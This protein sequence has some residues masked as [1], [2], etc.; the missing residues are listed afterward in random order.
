MNKKLQFNPTE[1]FILL[2]VLPNNNDDD[3]YSNNN[4]NN[5]STSGSSNINIKGVVEVSY[6]DT[7]H[8][9]EELGEPGVSAVPY[10]A[11]MAVDASQRRQGAATALLEAAEVVASSSQW[12]GEPRAV[13]HVFQDNSGAVELY[14]SRGYE[15]VFG[16][17]SW[18]GKLGA[19]PR[20]LMRKKL[21][22]D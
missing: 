5:S 22:T 1:R 15:V 7:K 16:D 17:A 2:I 6:L 11:S 12:W 4:N 10:I 9:L 21:G 14:K 13:L 18:W 8:V 19:R 20:Y 3:T